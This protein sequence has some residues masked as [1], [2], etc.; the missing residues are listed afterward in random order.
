MVADEDQAVNG[1]ARGE[2]LGIPATDDRDPLHVTAELAEQWER[3]RGRHRL[4]GIGNDG[5]DRAVEVEA[6]QNAGR[7]DP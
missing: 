6:E 1:Q 4:V 3:L 2:R 5:R 7:R